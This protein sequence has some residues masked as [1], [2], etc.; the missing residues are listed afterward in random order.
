MLILGIDTSD[1]NINISLQKDNELLCDIEKKTDRTEDLIDLLANTFKDLDLNKNEISA[2]GVVTGPGGYTGTRSGVSVAKTIAQILNIPI[3]GFNKLEAMLLSYS[4][5]EKVI[6][7]VD[8]KRNEAYSSLAIID[9]GLINYKKEPYIIKLQDLIEGLKEE[10]ESIT[11]LAYDFRDKKELF[12][13]LPNNIKVDFE[14][15]LQPSHIVKLVKKNL[16][17]NKITYFNDIS[18]FYIREAI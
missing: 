13:N 5:N 15:R 18:P 14:F 3:I 11:V 8:I 9:N 12:E 16:D 4:S 1:K 17:S 6:P 10:K 7:L 2:V